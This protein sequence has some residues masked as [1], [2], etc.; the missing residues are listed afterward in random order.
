RVASIR[1][2]AED[3]LIHCDGSGARSTAVTAYTAESQASHRPARRKCEIG[4]QVDGG[5]GGG[6][7][8]AERS[9]ERAEQCGCKDV[10]L[11][12]RAVFISG[13]KLGKYRVDHSPLPIAGIRNGESSEQTVRVGRVVI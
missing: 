11:G 8:P 3:S 5:S 12:K 10:V 9:P 2:P 7:R 1:A 13:G 4:R 6:M